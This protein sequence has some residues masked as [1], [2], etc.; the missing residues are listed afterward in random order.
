MLGLMSDGNSKLDAAKIFA[1]TL[2]TELSKN[3]INKAEVIVFSDDAYVQA[4]LSSAFNAINNQIS[5]IA[6]V[7]LTNHGNAAALLERRLKLH[8][9]D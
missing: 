4:P 8:K 9:N 5:Q 6:P 1:K 7:N 3:P 2:I